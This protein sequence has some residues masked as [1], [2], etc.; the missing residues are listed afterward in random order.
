VASMD[1]ATVST[2][3][4]RLAKIGSWTQIAQLVNNALPGAPVRFEVRPPREIPI[5]PGQVY[6]SVDSSSQHWKDV[7]RDKSVAVHLPPPFDPKKI[8]IELLAI[9]AD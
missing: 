4:P 3:V 8:S 9:P 6:F 2:Q 1:E 5:R 7:L